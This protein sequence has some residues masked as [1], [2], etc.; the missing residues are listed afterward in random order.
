MSGTLKDVIERTNYLKD[1]VGA[2][3][4]MVKQ[5]EVANQRILDEM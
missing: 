3:D 5:Y 2:L 1:E 4:N